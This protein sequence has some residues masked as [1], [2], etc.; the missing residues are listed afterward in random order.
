MMML[1]PIYGSLNDRKRCLQKN[2]AL[3]FAQNQNLPF[4]F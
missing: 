4:T 1:P 2:R 3:A